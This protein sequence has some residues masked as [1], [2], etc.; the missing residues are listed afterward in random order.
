MKE[1]ECFDF[2]ADTMQFH[3]TFRHSF[4]P[5]SLKLG[6]NIINRN[7]LHFTNHITQQTRCGF[8]E[9][10]ESH[11]IYEVKK[12]PSLL[13]FSFNYKSNTYFFKVIIYFNKAT[14]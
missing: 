14:E 8:F 1:Q 11:H 10:S 4:L 7:G 5:S 9:I 13:T 3:M 12:A 2:E 6:K